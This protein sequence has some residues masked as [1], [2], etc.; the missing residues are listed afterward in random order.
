MFRKGYLCLWFCNIYSCIFI[1]NIVNNTIILIYFPLQTKLDK[2][3]L[4]R[5]EILNCLIPLKK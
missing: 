3:Y 1:C 4:Y 5:G 2:T